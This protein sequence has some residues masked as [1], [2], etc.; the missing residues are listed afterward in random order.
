MKS[1]VWVILLLLVASLSFSSPRLPSTPKSK[2]KVRGP[3]NYQDNSIKSLCH[4]S[5]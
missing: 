2:L 4:R 1:S 5:E 3:N